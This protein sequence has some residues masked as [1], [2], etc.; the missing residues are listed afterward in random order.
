MTPAEPPYQAIA[1]DLRAAILAGTYQPGTAIPQIVDLQ[2]RYQVSRQTVRNAVR[3]LKD[4]GLVWARR[5]HGTVVRELPSQA[6]R[7]VRSR[8]MHR[9]DFGYYSDPESADWRS[10][11]PTVVSWSP[12][13]ADVADLLGV[14]TTANV[15]TRARLVGASRTEPR[16]VAT[17]YLHPDVARGTVLEQVSTGPGGVYDRLEEMGHGP[18]RWRER[19]SARSPSADE[20]R[21]LR[22][23]PGT[24]VLHVARVSTS[25]STDRVVDVTVFVMSAALYEVEHPVR[26]ATSARWPVSPAGEPNVPFSGADSSA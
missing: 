26:R 22:L 1:A 4:E 11:G 8:Q 6:R 25:S 15:L 14:E 5:R 9:D 13:P 24:P 18:L 3:V 21:A 10:L 7:A 23:L 19:I 20:A 2:E 17:S 12:A 16:Q